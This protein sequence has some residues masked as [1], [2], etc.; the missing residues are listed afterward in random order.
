MAILKSRPKVRVRVPNE[1]RPGEVFLAS[2]QLDCKRELDIA[3]VVVT[4]EGTEGWRIGSGNHSVQRKQEHVRLTARLAEATTL[5]KGRT[6]LSVRMPL[7]ID[8]P[9]SFRG[10]ASTIEYTLT[11]HVAIPWWADRRASF[12]IHVVPRER[13]SPETTPQIYSSRPEGPQ[14]REPHAEMSLASSWT[15]VGDVVS[16]ALAL[17]N[18]QHNRYSEIRVGL[19][20]LESLYEGNRQRHEIEHMRYQIRLGAEQAREGEMIPFRFRLPEGAMPDLGSTPRPDDVHG[21]CAV[22]WQLE[23]V[24]GIRWSSDLVLRVPFAVL[25]K[26]SQPGDV[27]LRLAPP[28][29]GSDRLRGVWEA[30]GTPH[31]LHYE[32]QSLHGRFG[33]TSLSIRRDH[34]G[35]D[36]IFVIAEL[37][38]PELFLGLE[39][40]PASAVQK[41]VGGGALIG[42]PSWDRDHYVRA[43]DEGQV[44]AVLR[45]LVPTMQNASLRRMDDRTLL[46]EVRDPGQSGPRMERFVAAAVGLAAR[47][48]EVRLA[49]PAPPRMIEALEEWRAL[50]LRIGGRL[51]TAR[52]RIDGQLSAMPTEVRLAFDEKGQP[53]TTWLSVSTPSPLDA[54]QRF[55]WRSADGPAAAAIERTYSGEARELLRILVDDVQELAIEP[56]RVTACLPALLG[57]ANEGRTLTGAAVEQRLTRIARLI[58]LL[59]GHAGPYR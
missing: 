9:P 49:V 37:R 20:G 34:M 32:A 55:S 31:G 4:L 18:V 13:Q 35:R 27:P 58:N 41:V 57:V 30:A 48:E 25:P 38:Y 42:D 11:V 52:M 46:V 56:D 16:G 21:F 19:R 26:S 54:S 59:R 28:T 2:I 6:E 24:V 17:S 8:A 5:Q 7:P 44:A 36:G 29:V 51:E 14:G 53:F 23:L 15:R 45:E 12:D 50:A 43:R 33:E 1:I 22:R 40:V 10:N 47:M 39:V 3:H